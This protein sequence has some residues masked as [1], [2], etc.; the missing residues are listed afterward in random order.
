MSTLLHDQIQTKAVTSHRTPKPAASVPSG[1]ASR[2]SADRCGLK[3]KSLR[4]LSPAR[5]HSRFCTSFLITTPINSPQRIAIGAAFSFLV[6]LSIL[7]ENRSP[8]QRLQNRSDLAL[9]ALIAGTSL[10]ETAASGPLSVP[11][12]N[13]TEISSSYAGLA[14]NNAARGSPRKLTLSSAGTV[15]SSVVSPPALRRRALYSS[16]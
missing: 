6:W 8:R 1:A 7:T 14:S 15:E 13:G 16:K 2:R 10:A 5:Y 3:T 12:P 4:S 9:P 11:V